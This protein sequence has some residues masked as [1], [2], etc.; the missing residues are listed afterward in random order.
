MK[1]ADV[2]RALEIGGCKNVT[3]E[4]FSR[5]PNASGRIKSVWV[6]PKWVREEYVFVGRAGSVRRGKN[7]TDSVNMEHIVARILRENGG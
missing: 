2:E 1:V 4:Y 6:H 3:T 7:R 5:K